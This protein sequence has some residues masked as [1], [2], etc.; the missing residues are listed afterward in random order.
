MAPST[1]PRSSA[2]WNKVLTRTA[3]AGGVGWNGN[4]ALYMA[5]AGLDIAAREYLDR[6]A[7]CDDT[8]FARTVDG[9]A[10]RRSPPR[11]AR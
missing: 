11:P 6:V 10:P 2:S 3:V 9:A 4:L 5:E 1:P 7:D 8:E